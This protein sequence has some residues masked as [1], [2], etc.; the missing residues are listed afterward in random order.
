M[1]FYRIW[2]PSRWSSTVR[3]VVTCRAWVAPLSTELTS[4]VLGL[5]LDLKCSVSGM[6]GDTRLPKILD[7]GS[8]RFPFAIKLPPTLMASHLH[9]PYTKHNYYSKRYYSTTWW[10]HIAR[11]RGTMA[12]RRSECRGGCSA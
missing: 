1:T 5:V 6:S 10:S 11:S 9:R 7:K 3:R 8:Y 2:G 4:D 12:D